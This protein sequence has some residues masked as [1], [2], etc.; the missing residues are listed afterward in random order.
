[1]RM[2]FSESSRHQPDPQHER[3]GRK[4]HAAE[5]HE[6]Y[7]CARLLR[8]GGC[9][10]EEEAERHDNRRNHEQQTGHPGKALRQARA[11]DVKHPEQGEN[12][13]DARVGVARPP[14]VLTHEIVEIALLSSIDGSQQPR[15]LKASVDTVISRMPAMR[16]DS[17]DMSGPP[18]ARLARQ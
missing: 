17:W 8:L 5:R 7:E 11:I 10:G 4:E 1:M 13:K 15:P 3:T 18:R 9:R 16:M 14:E 6:G 12:D 2:A